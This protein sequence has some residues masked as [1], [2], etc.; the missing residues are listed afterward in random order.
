M[1]PTVAVEDRARRFLV[2]PI[3]LEHVRPVH[4]DLAVAGDL[5]LDTGDGNADRAEPVL[6]EPVERDRRRALG[7]A[8]TLQDI[9]AEVAPGLAERG[10]ERGAAR[11]DV[12]EPAAELL[13]D[14]GE[15]DASQAHGQ[16]PRD[17]AQ[18]REELCLS[19]L[20]GLPLDAEEDGAHRS[21]RDEDHR[22]LA[23]LERAAD[24]R[25]L[26]ARRVDHRRAGEEHRPEAVRQRDEREEPLLR[27]DGEDLPCGLRVRQDV[28]VREHRSFRIAGRARREHDLR[29]VV[30]IEVR[31]GQRL[32]PARSIG[33]GL[34]VVERDAERRRPLAR[35][36]R[37]DG[38]GR[39]SLRD[40]LLR[41]LGQRVHVERNEDRADAE[42]GEERDPVL[43]P[44]DAP[45][46]HAVAALDPRVRERA[47]RAGHE[48]REIAVRPGA[49]AEARP[50]DERGLL[51]EANGRRADDLVQ[52]V[53]A[54]TSTRS[55][56]C[57]LAPSRSGG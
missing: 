2:L 4:Q 56:S 39:A 13:V 8:V 51:S 42:R 27:A 31:R 3:A 54:H 12:A 1:I 26:A 55:R 52:R 30:T 7:G 22:D 47:R 29:E 49:S 34:H 46:D 5:H 41:E 11:D 50:D 6:V 24:D 53:Q 43:G 20:L 36:R 10:I 9:D 37:H 38:G 33:Q 45:D 15:E 28:P 25:R 32:L 19:L 35:L 23:F 21:G 48:V 57:A 17:L 40:D 44:V 18:L 16:S 14:A